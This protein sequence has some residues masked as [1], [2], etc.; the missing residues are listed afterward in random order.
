[1]GSDEV[2]ELEMVVEGVQLYS[3]YTKVYSVE[4]TGDNGKIQFTS[5][6]PLTPGQD[7]IITVR[8]DMSSED[9]R[10][11]E[12]VMGSIAPS[13]ADAIAKSWDADTSSDSKWSEDNPALGQCA[14][15]SLVIQD[16]YG[17]EL[18]RGRVGDTSHYWNLLPNG[19]EVDLTRD[20]F[21]SF[22]LEAT[23]ITRDRSYVL[24]FPDTDTRY[25]TLRQR[26]RSHLN[27]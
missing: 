24:Q 14:V 12:R 16:L 10:T 26:V 9:D 18:L 7:L 25:Q 15:T 6:T 2:M 27:E 19:Q 4:A 17:G 8:V 11:P 22:E 21:D 23:P 1:M 5:P 13:Y 3:R 20:Q